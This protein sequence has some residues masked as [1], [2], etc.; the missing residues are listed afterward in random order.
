MAPWPADR[1]G[2]RISRFSAGKLIGPSQQVNT[3]AP[4]QIHG[5]GIN[6]PETDLSIHPWENRGGGRA[7]FLDFAS[8]KE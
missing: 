6:Q 2:V 1:P 7:E 8:C 5:H 4:E 3:P